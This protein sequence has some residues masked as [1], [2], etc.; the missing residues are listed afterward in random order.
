MRTLLI[1]LAIL[2]LSACGFVGFPGVYRINIEQGNII[3]Q[4]LVD[5]LHPGMSRRQVRFILGTPLVEDPFNQQRWDYL[6][7]IRNG[8]DIIDEAHLSVFFEGDKLSHY[9]GSFDQTPEEDPDAVPLP[10]A[11]EVLPPGG[12]E[13]T[14]EQAIEAAPPVGGPSA[15]TIQPGPGP[16]R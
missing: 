11:T 7:V 12:L 5:Q 9:T 13:G 2:S 6:Y 3:N 16:T 4:E 10:D 14:L 15:G 1:A 8:A